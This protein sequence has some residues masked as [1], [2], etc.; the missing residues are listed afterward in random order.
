MGGARI[1]LTWKEAAYPPER[2]YITSAHGFSF[3]EGKVLLVNLENRGWDIPSG[4]IEKVESHEQCFK[5]E[6][7]EEGCVVAVHT[8]GIYYSRPY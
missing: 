6:A 4:H 3:L 2:E 8:S 7:M 1:K 5:R